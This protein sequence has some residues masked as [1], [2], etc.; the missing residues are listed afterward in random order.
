MKDIWVDSAEILMR[1]G[2][3]Q[4]A[5]EMLNEAHLACSAFD[6]ASLRAK[7]LYLLGKASISDANATRLVSARLHEATKC[8]KSIFARIS[9]Y[10]YGVMFGYEGE[11][12][13]SSA[14]AGIKM[15][16]KIL[17]TFSVLMSDL[18]PV[19][20]DAVK[21]L[22]QEIQIFSCNTNLILHLISF[23]QACIHRS[24]VQASH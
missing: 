7:V 21:F 13:L 5:R 9:R 10:F 20:M 18:Q 14:P 16:R 22:S 6:D 11:S 19:I 17:Y 4:P 24:P 12:P 15:K 23:R 3:Y 8:L 2:F 1:Q